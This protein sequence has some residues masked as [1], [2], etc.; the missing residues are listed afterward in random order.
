V[1][2]DFDQMFE[3]QMH[4][5]DDKKSRM[6]LKKRE[7]DRCMSINDIFMLYTNDAWIKETDDVLSWETEEFK[8]GYQNA[9]M[10]F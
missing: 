2:E 1:D 6:F 7:H 10:K 8:K 3:E 5:Y 9:I 4:C